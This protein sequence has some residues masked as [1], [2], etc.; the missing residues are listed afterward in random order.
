MSGMATVF[1]LDDDD[2]VRDALGAL[3]K[4]CG[5]SV[6]TY[7]SG[8]AFLANLGA[9]FVGCVVLDVRMPGLSGLELQKQLTEMNIPLPVIIITGHGDLPMAVKA[10]KA[11]AVDFIEKPFDDEEILASVHEALSRGARMYADAVSAAALNANLKRLTAREREVLE[12]VVLGH[13]NKA[14]AYSLGISPR[15]VEIHR[16]R[17]IEKLRARNL[18]HLVRMAIAAGIVDTDNAEA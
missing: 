3:F 7:E 17:V 14:I 10:M 1:I 5:L 18:S 2:A 11:G 16:A 12:Q 9:D 15:T 13:P 8:E 4:S 6:R